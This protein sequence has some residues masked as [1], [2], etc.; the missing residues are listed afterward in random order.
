MLRQGFEG[1]PQ[2]FASL[3]QYHPSGRLGEVADIARAAFYLADTDSPFLNGAVVGVDGGI[4]GRLHD[5]E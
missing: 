5:P 4:A 2:A 1:R 3:G